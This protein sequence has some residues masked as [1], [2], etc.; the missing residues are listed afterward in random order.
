MRQYIIIYL[1]LQLHLLG[2]SEAPKSTENEGKVT[3]IY[4]D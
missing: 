4:R 2:S 1:F 3:S